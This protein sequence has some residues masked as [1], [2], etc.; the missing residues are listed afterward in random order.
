MACVLRFQ[1]ERP[2]RTF[3]HEPQ[4]CPQAQIDGQEHGCILNDRLS[5]GLISTR[6][7]PDYGTTQ[8]LARN[9]GQ[10]EHDKHDGDCRRG[11]RQA[12]TLSGH[13]EKAISRVEEWNH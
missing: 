12:L 11:G 8:H 9:Q 13:I 5:D 1:S 4:P 2:E 7:Q 3:A 10:H 6:E